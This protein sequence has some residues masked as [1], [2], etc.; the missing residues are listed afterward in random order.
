MYHTQNLRKL[1]Q[2]SV[3]RKLALSDGNIALPSNIH[4]SIFNILAW[5]NIDQLQETISGKGTF[6][7]VNGIA[8]QAKYVGPQQV[9]VIPSIAESKQKSINTAKNDDSYIQHWAVSMTTNH[10]MFRH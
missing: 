4:D 3:S 5:D 6:H 10:S 1:I 2:V 9:K 8:V 7:R